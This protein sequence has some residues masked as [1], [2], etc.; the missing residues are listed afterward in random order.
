MPARYSWLTLITL[1]LIKSIVRSGQK[2]VGTPRTQPGLQQRETSSPLLLTLRLAYAI[3]KV[4]SK[5][6]GPESKWDTSASGIR[7]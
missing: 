2:M 5:P 7:R 4:Q 6:G 3:T 1:Y